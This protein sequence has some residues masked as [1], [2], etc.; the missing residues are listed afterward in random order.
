[1]AI[2]R[3][4]RKPRAA[5]LT[6][7]HRIDQISPLTTVSANASATAPGEGG[8]YSGVTAEAQTIC[9]T[10]T[11]STSATSGGSQ[12]RSSRCHHGVVRSTGVSRA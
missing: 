4:S 7:V 11:N 12:V 5:R 6:E 2:T 8:R 3:A 9:Q 1:M 10:T